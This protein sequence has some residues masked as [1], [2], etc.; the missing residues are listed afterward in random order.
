MKR[1]FT[2][3]VVW[4]F[5]MV[6]FLPVKLDAQVH[7]KGLIAG[8][9]WTKP[10]SPYIIDSAILVASLTVEPGVEIRFSGNYVFEVAGILTAK[11]TACDSVRFTRQATATW[12]GIL[13]QNSIPG[14]EMAYCVVEYANTSGI[15][16]FESFPNIHDCNIRNST[17]ANSGGG[18]KITNTAAAVLEI[19][20]CLIEGNTI[21]TNYTVS[22]SN[23]AGAWV[24]AS[25]GTVRFRNCFIKNNKCTRSDGYTYGGGAFVAGNVEFV[26]C[27]VQDNLTGGYDGIPGGSSGGNGGGIYIDNGTVNFFNTTVNNNRA[28]GTA[29]GG[30]SGNQGYADGGGIKINNGQVSFFNSIITNNTAA[31]THGTRG[32]GLF[33]NAGQAKIENSTF[34]NNNPHAI[35]N[36]ADT[37]R[38][39]NSILYFNNGNGVQVT[40]KLSIVFSD[41]QG[42]Y[43]GTGNINFNPLFQGSGVYK[44]VSP[45]P[46]IDAGSDSAK[47]NDACFPPSLGNSRNDMGA[48]GGPQACTWNNSTQTNCLPLPVVWLYFKGQPQGEDVQL[49]WATASGQNT[50]EFVVARSPDGR[51]FT[52]IGTVPAAGNSS[53]TSSY[54]YTDQKAMALNKHGVYYRLKQIDFDNKFEYSSVVNIKGKQE[55][56]ALITAY[57]NPFTKSLTLQLSEPASG[58]ADNVELYSSD[59]RLLYRHRLANNTGTTVLLNDLPTLSKG[60]YLLKAVV[61]EKPHRILLIKNE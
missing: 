34:A 43:T 32:G 5:F 44:I 47:Y 51:N 45:S 59:G 4:C 13:F 20:N 1:Y 41:V 7:K 22:E 24:S 40:G 3:L 35:H 38:T 46:C 16:I 39:V 8:E 27:T 19:R 10:N 60:I 26:L 14:T 61:N 18:L 31:S 25:N 53:Q 11:G 56:G 12:Q 30:M 37:I 58:P 9:T 28:E 33:V 42:G 50:K 17:S 23:G 36:N 49:T 21:A 15:R 6:L 54:Q 48:H 52:A 55:A 29:A 57:P 2:R